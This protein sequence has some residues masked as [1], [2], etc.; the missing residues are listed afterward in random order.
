MHRRRRGSADKDLD[1]SF[2][3][4][5]IIHNGRELV[6]ESMAALAFSVSEL[7]SSPDG[8]GRRVV[9]SAFC[10]DA[11]QTRPACPMVARF[12]PD[13]AT[14]GLSRL[15]TFAVLDDKGSKVP[16]DNR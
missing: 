14:R 13:G 3:I 2:N 7:A 11:R 8:S 12:N 10:R 15:E 5:R 6:V 9:L 4:V 16:K 1:A